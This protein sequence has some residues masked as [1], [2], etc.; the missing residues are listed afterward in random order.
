MHLSVLVKALRDLKL[1]IEETITFAE[2]RQEEDLQDDSLFELLEQCQKSVSAV[3]LAI[4]DPSNSVS[5]TVKI[6]DT[7]STEC[8]LQG[9]TT[10]QV[11]DD[12]ENLDDLDFDDF[13]DEAVESKIAEQSSITSENENEE[14]IKQVGLN[15]CAEESGIENIHCIDDDEPDDVHQPTD[16][17]YQEVLKQYFGYSNFRPMQ[18]KIINSV[19]NDKRDNCVIM[20]TGYGKS[21]TFQFP[22]VFTKRVSII[23][24]PLI[25]LME[26]QVHG[27]KASNIEACFLGS[28]QSK[29]ATVKQD[30]FSGKYRLVY[31]TPEFATTAISD[32]KKLDELVGIDLIAIDEAH[33]VSQWGH[34][35]RESYRRLGILKQEFPKIPI[36]A[37]T[38]TA[39]FDVQKDICSS[40]RLVRPNMTCTG[41]DRPNL[42]LNVEA[43]HGDIAADL[44]NFMQKVGYKFC[45]DGPTIIYCPTKKVTEEVTSALNGLDVPCMSYH[46]SLSFSARREAH[47]SFLNDKIQVVV[48]TVAFGMGIDKPDIRRVIHYGAPKDI[49]SYYQEIGRAGRDGLPSVCTTLFS[50]SDFNLSRHFISAIPSEKFRD[51]KLKMLQKMEQYLSTTSCRRRILLSYFESGNLKEIGGTLNCCDNCRLR[52]AK[53]CHGLDVSADSE[54][55]V[56]YRKEAADLFK[57][58][59]ATGNRYGLQVPILVLKGSE[60]QKVQFFKSNKIFGAGKYKSASFWTALGRALIY[61]GYL[62][63]KAVQG[64]FGSTVETTQKAKTWLNRLN[65][66]D[67]CH[68]FITPTGDL[69]QE[70]EMQKKKSVVSVSM[71]PSQ[72]VASSYVVKPSISA[73]LTADSVSGSQLLPATLQPSAPPK[74]DRIVRLE[75][76]LY[77]KL[78]KTRNSISQETGFTP[79][80]IASN[81]VLLDMAKFRP[82]TRSSLLKLED[83]PEVKAD[84]F[85]DKFLEFIKSFCSQYDLKMDEF[86]EELHAAGTDDSIGAIKDTLMKISETQRQSYIMFAVNNQSLEEVASRRGLKVST[87][88]THLCEAMKEGLNVDIRRLGVT[89]K[90]E[91]LVTKAIW[92][93]PVNGGINSLTKIKDQLPEYVEYNHIKVVVALLVQKHGQEKNSNDEIVLC[94]NAPFKQ[95]IVDIDASAETRQCLKRQRT[96]SPPQPPVKASCSLALS[97]EPNSLEPN[98]LQKSVSDTQTS[99]L[100]QSQSSQSPS[101]SSSQA[102]TRKLPFWIAGS[103]NKT[104]LKKKMK[105]N[106]LFK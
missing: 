106:S 15:D 90:M 54:K 89:E 44:K 51:H 46:A 60:T 73:S 19:L 24:C 71:K 22:S 30:M 72:A 67:E 62:R 3:S 93:P 104:L 77:V 94:G 27:L 49:E 43:K 34:D 9:Q 56:D 95:E 10:E 74:D 96:Q 4:H 87:V 101:Q 36:L 47:H 50:R 40:L 42:F 37:V 86:P 81:K 99:C 39:T 2:T 75:T 55:S 79:H 85:G 61:E 76:D 57:A 82:S 84:R 80:N 58:I 70:E 14:S 52:S 103:A 63:E 18:W 48:A 16:P 35:F 98:F 17:V 21:L 66:S 11:L 5:G 105:S 100:Q 83:F 6:A 7:K 32:F 65:R 13:F 69:Q 38:A 41:F 28:A 91:N 92:A 23:I 102:S 8:H 88:V 31:V 20:A 45:F 29:M 53:I 1:Q 26:D 68:L 25:S 64:G 78:V 33:C 59:E 12:F 97:P